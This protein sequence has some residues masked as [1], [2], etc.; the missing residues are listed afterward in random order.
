MHTLV[1]WLPKAAR[2]RCDVAPNDHGPFSNALAQSNI[3]V[4]GG[5]PELQ[6]STAPNCY[7][8]LR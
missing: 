4:G 8:T 5:Q 6:S 7:T 2:I 3:D 1:D